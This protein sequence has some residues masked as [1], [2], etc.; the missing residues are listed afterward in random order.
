MDREKAERTRNNIN[1]V[2][3]NTKRYC[4][5]RSLAECD[6][7]R[8]ILSPENT[9]VDCINNQMHEIYRKLGTLIGEGINGYYH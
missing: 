5:K 6:A 3:F 7:H 9:N 4:N 2:F 8:C 1:R